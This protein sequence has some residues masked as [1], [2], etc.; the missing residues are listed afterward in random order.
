MHECICAGITYILL[1]KRINFETYADE[2]GYITT[3][4]DNG[5]ELQ[6]HINNNGCM[7][8]NIWNGDTPT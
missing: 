1:M 3:Q 5:N 4:K 8:H 2:E 6:T 7:Y